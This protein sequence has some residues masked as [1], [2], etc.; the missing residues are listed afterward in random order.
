[1]IG[2]RIDKANKVAKRV[3]LEIEYMRESNDRG[4]GKLRKTRCS[5]SCWMC[6]HRRKWEGITL[7]ERKLRLSEQDG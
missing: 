1:M 2:K 4:F 7:Q 5:C 3:S 6:G